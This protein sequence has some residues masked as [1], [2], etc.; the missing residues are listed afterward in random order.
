MHYMRI[1][2]ICGVHADCFNIIACAVF[3]IFSNLD[4]RPH[5]P[6]AKQIS[7]QVRLMGGSIIN[8]DVSRASSTSQ[9]LVTYLLL[10][11]QSKTLPVV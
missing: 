11:Q 4:S 3:G 2:V 10:K 1:A 6:T 9:H 7:S 5:L 8:S